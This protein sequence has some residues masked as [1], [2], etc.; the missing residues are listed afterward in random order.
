MTNTKLKRKAKQIAVLVEMGIVSVNEVKRKVKPQF[1][2]D[3]LLPLLKETYIPLTYLR[4]YGGI[5]DLIKVDIASALTVIDDYLSIVEWN[6]FENLANLR[7]SIK[8]TTITA[9]E[10]QQKMFEKY[11]K[12]QQKI[13]YYSKA[14]PVAVKI[15]GL[16]LD[17]RIETFSK[18]I[19]EPNPDGATKLY[20][21][22]KG[23]KL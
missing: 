17:E 7:N 11:T 9:D 1:Y 8:G 6:D 4:I 21:L 12:A 19:P 10:L 23:V 5:S 3:Y 20:Y 2:Q 14:Y 18:F 15:L 13:K 22:I 16:S